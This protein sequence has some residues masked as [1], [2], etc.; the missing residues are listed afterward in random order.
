VERA[1]GR[2]HRGVRT[3][4]RGLLVGGDPAARGGRGDPPRSRTH[5]PDGVGP[6][7]RVAAASR[8]APCGP[9]RVRRDGVPGDRARPVELRPRGDGRS[10]RARASR[11]GDRRQV[12]RSGSRRVRESDAGRRDGLLWRSSVASVW[13]TKARWLRSEASSRRTQP[14]RSTASRSRCAVR[15]RTTGAPPSGPPRQQGGANV[16]R[17]PGSPACV[18]CSA[19]RSCASEASSPKPRTRRG[20]RRP[21]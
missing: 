7:E 20:K 11:A 13:W 12:R 1:P 2:E 4:L 19:P 17:S 18:A 5:G 10:E 3:R 6:V 15:S 8:P 21:S 9:A 14:A 16:S